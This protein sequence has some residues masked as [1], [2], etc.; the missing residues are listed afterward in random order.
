MRTTQITTPETGTIQYPNGV[1]FMYSRQPVIIQCGTNASYITTVKVTC[2]T[3]GGASYTETRK[4]LKGRAEFDISR[5]MQTLARDVDGVLQRLDYESGAALAEVFSLEVTVSNNKV[6][7]LQSDIQ[8]L[9]GA[10]DACEIYGQ[11]TT[12]RLFVNYPQTLNMWKDS[13]GYF[14]VN[15]AGLTNTPPYSAASALCR[16]VCPQAFLSSSIL[17]AL[18]NGQSM[19]GWTSWLYRLQEGVQSTQQTRDITLIPDTSPR[20]RGVYLRWLNRRGEVSYW[21]FDK[22]QIET[23]GA[24]SEAF[25]RHYEGDPA[26]PVDKVFLNEDKRSYEEQRRLGITTTGLSEEEFDD[27][28]TLLTSPVVEMLYQAEEYVGLGLVVD[29]G[30]AA[31]VGESSV[32]G[33]DST[34]NLAGLDG[35]SAQETQLYHSAEDRWIRVN[36]EGGTQ[37]RRNR[38]STPRLHDFEATLTLI[39]RNTARL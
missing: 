11:S 21:R 28:C 10:L 26:A 22:T 20:G 14:R 6:L 5:I 4:M 13:F 7:T 12:R 36:V 39:Q 15:I 32:D 9:Y 16:E 37:G 33:Q 2:E 27:L 8:A 24:V 1:A 31:R 29:G 35:G 19:A 30:T 18:R 38:H 23:A 25:R 17:T 3:N 34:A